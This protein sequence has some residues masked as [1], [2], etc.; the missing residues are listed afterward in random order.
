[1]DYSVE[2]ARF[3]LGVVEFRLFAVDARRV[4]SCE[5]IRTFEVHREDWENTP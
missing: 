4:P 5:C 3:S 2:G 1:M